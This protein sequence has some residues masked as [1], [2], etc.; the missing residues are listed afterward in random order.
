MGVRRVDM[1]QIDQDNGGIIAMAETLNKQ[2]RQQRITRSVVSTLFHGV[3]WLALL[4]MQWGPVSAF[5]DTAR[6][7]SYGSLFHSVL[8]F[9]TLV[10]DHPIISIVSTMLL[11]AV[12]FVILY[13]LDQSGWRRFARECWTAVFVTPAVLGVLLSAMSLLMDYRNHMMRWYSQG[14]EVNEVTEEWLQRMK[15]L[16][17]EWKLV[18]VEQQGQLTADEDLPTSELI[19]WR[20]ESD[21]ISPDVTANS[22]YRRLVYQYRW[23]IG[24]QQ[25]RGHVDFIKANGISLSERFVLVDFSDATEHLHQMGVCHRENSRLKLC[26][27]PPGI[28]GYDVPTTFST[29]EHSDDVIYI[30]ELAQTI[31]P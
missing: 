4:G 26:L 28:G 27:A 10:F 15:Q 7:L 29:A 31:S 21:G 6:G 14:R 25:R 17:G 22:K 8:A 30:F 2:N 16:E 24:N 23:T 11:L 3:C 20:F 19:I 13:L 18:G 9:A 1:Y 5:L 12:D